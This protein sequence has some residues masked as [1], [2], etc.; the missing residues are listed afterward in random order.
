VALAKAVSEGVTDFQALAI[1]GGAAETPVTPCGACRQ[2]LVEFCPPRMPV[3]YAGLAIGSA[4][5]TTLGK[6]LPH[7]FTL[8]RT[9]GLSA[10]PGCRMLSP[11]AAGSLT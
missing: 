3:W 5:A 2:V 6:L 8:P 1:A 10:A 4:R 11:T 9:R 7:A